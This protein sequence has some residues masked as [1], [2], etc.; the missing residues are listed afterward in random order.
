MITF[1]GTMADLKN[2]IKVERDQFFRRI[3]K[4]AAIT[5][6]P[7]VVKSFVEDEFNLSDDETLVLT[8]MLI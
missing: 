4:D 2:F 5:E 1:F 7:N 8:C 6:G 3:I